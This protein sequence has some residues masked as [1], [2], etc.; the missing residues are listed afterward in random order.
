MSTY[1]LSMH[2]ALNLSTASAMNSDK[3]LL[4]SEQKLLQA[5]D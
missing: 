4:W 3:G 5:H 1:G 2:K